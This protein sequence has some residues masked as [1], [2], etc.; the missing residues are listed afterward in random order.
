VSPNGIA[1]SLRVRRWI[2]A[3]IFLP[4]TVACVVADC[5]GQFAGE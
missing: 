5:F 4:F 1:V 2:G 3:L